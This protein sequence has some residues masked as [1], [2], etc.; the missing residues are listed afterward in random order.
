MIGRVLK[1]GS[2][3]TGLL[4][5]LYGPGKACEHV[6]PRLVSGWRHPAELE[7]PLRPDGRRDFRRLTGLLDMPVALLGDRAPDDP[8]WHCVVR[9]APGDP[10][11]GDGAWM[12]IAGEVMHRTGL[13]RHGEEDEGVRWV[14]VHHGDNHIHIVAT[15]ARQDGRRAGLHNEYYQIGEA[16]R[17]IEAEYGLVAVVRADR[18][19]S[20]RPTRAEGEK[21]ARSGRSEP[22]RVTLLRHVQAAAAA[23]RSEAEFFAALVRRGVQ[24][25]LRYSAERPGEVTGYAVTVAGARTAAGNPVWFGGGKLAPDLSLPK[26]RARWPSPGRPRDRLDGNGMRD[27]VARVT[28]RHEVG[29]RAARA[30]SEW[31]FFAALEAAG[32]TV[33]I[34]HGSSR[35]GEAAGYAVSLPG[36]VDRAGQQVW[37]GGQILSG[38]LGLGSLRHRWRAG[39][40]GAPPAPPFT[41]TEIGEIYEYAAAVATEA[42]RQLHTS[43]SPDQAADI[44]W[45]AADVLTVAADVT[46]NAE[47]CRAADGFARAA[48]APWGRTPPPSPA[49]ARL[50]TTAYL[51]AACGPGGSRRTAIRRVLINALAGIA[52]AVVQLR[53]AQRRHAQAAAARNAAVGLAA[54]ASD[55]ATG[56]TTLGMIIETPGPPVTA[57]RAGWVADAR[58]A[59][60]PPA[61]YPPRRPR[62]AR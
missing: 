11:L 42:A 56:P 14:A 1:R 2:N 22:P 25:R 27:G 36:L 31:E 40:P 44:A 59:R 48:R 61:S 6:N 16:L 5:Y 50:R 17:D 32:L 3:L 29:L 8:V 52:D 41:G 51:L 39:R 24:V 62:R 37:Y 35:S 9:A 19:A 12:R 46:G 43:P 21:A 7:P 60:R 33:R 58:T 47:L 57:R 13:S 34:R 54:F 4:Y 49:G 20:R 15:L 18:T 45:G 28:L 26:L 38:Q 23:A 10:E 30:R 53:S 55:T